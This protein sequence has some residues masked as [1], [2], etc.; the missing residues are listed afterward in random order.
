MINRRNQPAT[1]DAWRARELPSA[2]LLTNNISPAWSPDGE[3]I[4]FPHPPNLLRVMNADGSGLRTLF[5]TRDVGR[6]GG[7]SWQPV[8]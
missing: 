1:T 8:R 2:A 5:R 6:F 3:Q 4:V 7:T